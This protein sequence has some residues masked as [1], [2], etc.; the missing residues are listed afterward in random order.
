MAIKAFSCSR[1]SANRFVAAVRWA[2]KSILSPVINFSSKLPLIIEARALYAFI[3]PWIA[4]EIAEKNA[5]PPIEVRAAR[6]K[7]VRQHNK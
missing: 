7:Y 4:V 3:L 6:V 5:R 2:E 1:Y